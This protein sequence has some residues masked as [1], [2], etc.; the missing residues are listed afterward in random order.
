MAAALGD[1]AWTASRERRSGA[2]RDFQR[3]PGVTM[4][5]GTPAAWLASQR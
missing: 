5:Y 4:L 1:G 3:G 2:K